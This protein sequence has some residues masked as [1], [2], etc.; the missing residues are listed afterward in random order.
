MH[1]KITIWLSEG[2]DG[3]ILVD[4]ECNYPI[5]AETL[6]GI[7]ESDS[8]HVSKL[9][10]YAYEAMSAINECAEEEDDV[11]VIIHYY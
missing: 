10:R 6:R 3:E 9:E 1:K 2:E 7:A 5:D 8:C 11:D 4:L